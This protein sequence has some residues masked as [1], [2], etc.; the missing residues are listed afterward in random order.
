MQQIA[1][2]DAKIIV[3]GGQESMSMAPHA[4]HLRAGTKMGDLKLID[5]M[6]KDG[7]M[8]AFH[9]Y[10]MGNTAENVA[11][12]WQITRDEQDQFAVA[13]QNKAEAAQKAGKLQGR[14]RR[15]SPSRAARATSIVDQDEYIRARRDARERCRSCAR[16]STRT[17]R[18]P[19]ATRRAS[20]TAPPP[21][22]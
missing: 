14:D 19:P 20:T 8:D 13:S 16:P 1:T 11:R 6:I 4:A 9:G 2:G 3:A 22:C 18:S 15:P 12:Q 7:L 21:W 5:T 17:A 10:H